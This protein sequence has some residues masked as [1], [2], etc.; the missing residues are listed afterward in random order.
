MKFKMAVMPIYGIHPF[1]RL[2]LQNHWASLVD[3][4]HEAYKI[5]YIIYN[6]KYALYKI[7]DPT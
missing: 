1:K 5:C 2:L 6:I 7:A 3:I 4:L